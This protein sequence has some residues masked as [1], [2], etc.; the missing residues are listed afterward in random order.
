MEYTYRAEIV[1][2][3]SVQD[4]ITE[5]LEEKIENIE[6]TVI[7]GVMGKGR[8]SKKLGNT[9]DSIGYLSLIIR[10]YKET[11]LVPKTKSVCNKMEMCFIALINLLIC[12]NDY[13]TAFEYLNI[14][15][16]MCLKDII[17]L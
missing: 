4:V 8:H 14:L 6:Y 5:L 15:M 9:I 11:K 2:N 13:F 7:P 17:Y 10:L 1:A 12:N 3:Q 16:D